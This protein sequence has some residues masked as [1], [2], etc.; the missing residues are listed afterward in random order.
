MSDPK[1]S[2]SRRID[3]LPF[4]ALADDARG[5]D[6]VIVPIGC[7]EPHGRHAPLGTDTL[8]AQGIADRIAE[9]SGALVFSAIPLGTLNVLYDFR[10]APGAISLDSRVLLDVYTNVGTELMRQG[11]DRL[12]FVNGHSGNAPLLQVAAFDIKARAGGQVGLLE[13]WSAAREIIDGIKGHSWGTH[14]DEIETSILMAA[15]G[16]DLV[17]LG[18]AVANPKELDDLDDDER[19]L[20]EQKILFTRTLDHRWVGESANMGDPSLARTEDG[21]AIVRRC[22]DVGIQ[23]L[24][25]LAQQADLERAARPKP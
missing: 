9:A 6:A 22:V 25:V 11:F 1:R 3:R 18:S 15:A 21:E 12:L 7:V 17:D 10:D 4:Q 2:G 14:A 20:Y 16:E 5:T 23:I 24:Q 8:I 13:W 19:S